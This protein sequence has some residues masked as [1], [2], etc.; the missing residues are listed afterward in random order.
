MHFFLQNHQSK[1]VIGILFLNAHK[2]QNFPYWEDIKEFLFFIQFWCVFYY[3][4]FI[5]LGFTL[6]LTVSEINSTARGQQKLNWKIWTF[7]FFIQF[8]CSF[9]KVIILRGYWWTKKILPFY[10]TKGSKRAQIPKF[11]VFGRCLE[12]IVFILFFSLYWLR[13]APT[14]TFQP[15]LDFLGF[16]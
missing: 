9:C 2:F 13:W 3:C 8:Y 15:I 11:C 10:F 1:W 7:I 6:L 4:E 5:E 14:V 12:F 16:I